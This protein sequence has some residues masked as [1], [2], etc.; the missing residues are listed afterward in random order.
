[1]GTSTQI[2]RLLLAEKPAAELLGISTRSLRRLAAAGDLEK[3]TLSRRIVRYRV[4]DLRAM[5]APR[6]E[7]RPPGAAEVWARPRQVRGG[8]G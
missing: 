6:Q 2:E 5:A 3:V 7:A 1:M 8:R 4:A